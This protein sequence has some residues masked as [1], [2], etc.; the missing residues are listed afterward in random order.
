[1]QL[2]GLTN[3]DMTFRA[4]SQ[5][6]A[7]ISAVGTLSL[8]T[9]S[10]SGRMD[11]Y[12]TAGNAA[13]I[14]LLGSTSQM[15]IFGGDNTEKVS[16]DAS[17]GWGQLVLHNN[18]AADQFAAILTA[19]ATGGGSL[20]LYN[21]N[22]LARASLFGGNGGGTMN[23]YRSDGSNT[24]SIVADDGTGSGL[25][26]TSVLQITG[27]AD[28]SEQF[29]VQTGDGNLQPGMVVCIDAQHPGQL[30]VSS[31]PYD[32]T[33]AGIIS[34]AGGISPGM[35]MGHHGTVA[36]GK[37]AVALT[38]RVY[39]LADATVGPIHP[40]DLLTTSMTPGHAMK[41]SDPAR[42]Q[43]A[44]LGKAMASLETGKGLVLVLVTL[45]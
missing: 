17:P 23:L 37:H 9:T 35:L 36:D 34:G 30:A 40:G 1:V 21:S 44:I 14:S 15:R 2:A 33:V 42:A 25:V 43:G 8:G 31:R 18:T 11:V 41:V 13:S 29:D 28:L 27:G 32:R 24:V 22:G 7:R 4:G 5:E 12:R 39:C 45:Q 10:V 6:R 38:G 16:L 26:T 19:N 20:T 3:G